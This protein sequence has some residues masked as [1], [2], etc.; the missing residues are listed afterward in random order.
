VNTYLTSE[1]CGDLGGLQCNIAC[2]VGQSPR[3]GP[4]TRPGKSW[5]TT[6]QQ[7]GA[8]LGPVAFFHTLPPRP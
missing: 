6:A 3:G 2:S 8:S 4:Q 7:G 1:V 5:A